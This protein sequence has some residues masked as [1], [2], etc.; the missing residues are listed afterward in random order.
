L[1]VLGDVAV[2]IKKP[3]RQSMGNA[4]LVG[5]DEREDVAGRH[6]L[7]SLRRHDLNHK[8]EGV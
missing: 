3:S 6:G 4:W 7:L 8:R 1:G 2:D 5:G